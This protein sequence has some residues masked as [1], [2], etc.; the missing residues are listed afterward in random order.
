MTSEEI[1]KNELKITALMMYVRE[2]KHEVNK[3][4]DNEKGYIR[5]IEDLRDSMETKNEV[6]R[7][8]SIEIQKLERKGSE[9]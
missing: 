6:I 4:K 2:L 5:K 1:E 8:V 3:D 7:I 9:K